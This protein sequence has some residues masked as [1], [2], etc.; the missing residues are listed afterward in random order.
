[1]GLN[2]RYPGEECGESVPQS[3]F[4]S[5]KLQPPATTIEN[6]VV[7]I[8]H[9]KHIFYQQSKLLIFLKKQNLILIRKR[10]G[11]GRATQDRR[12]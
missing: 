10:K 6:A 12:Q 8:H 3:H 11:A 9:L 2:S 7:N 1:M 5:L 4:Y